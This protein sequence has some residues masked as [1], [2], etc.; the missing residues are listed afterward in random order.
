MEKIIV[1]GAAGFI[2]AALINKLLENNYKVVGIDNLNDYYDIKLKQDRLKNIEKLNYKNIDNWFFE[3][4]NLVNYIEIEKIFINYKPDIV[5]NLAAQAGVRYSIK[6]P[7][8]YIESNIVGF[9]NILELSRKY[10]VRNFIFASSSS[11][12]G[13]N[14]ELPFCENHTVNH[15][16]NLYG[17]SKVSNEVIA[18]SYSYLFKIPITGLRFF[19][20]YGP[21]GRPDM[22][23][24]IF[25][26]LM[27]KGEEIVL[28]K[29]GTMM[30]D[31]TYI[32]DIVEGIYK[33]AKK[34]ATPTSKFSKVNYDPS[35]SEAPFRLF[36]IGNGLPI[37][38]IDFVEILEDVL[39]IRA[40]KKYS[41]NTLGEMD[42]TEAD[43]K[44]L[45]DWI[46]FKPKIKLRTGT[47]YF[48]DWFKEYYN[49]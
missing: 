7:K 48:V 17:A 23:P 8:A 16:V 11:V 47:K 36:N 20:V 10:N 9:Y 29:R 41:D 6:N 28:N 33:C 24:F 15:P 34:P 18:H 39:N 1:T 25:T 45:E 40:I 22:A 12:Y 21:W 32:D 46:K 31:F 44:K 30:R 4:C 14:K 13:G 19:T 49:F 26:K 3:K 43:T 27:L 35:I 38:I 42:N 5:I 37:K 2:G